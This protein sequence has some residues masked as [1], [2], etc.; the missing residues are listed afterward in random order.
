MAT[1]EQMIG[2]NV[3]H[4]LRFEILPSHDQDGNP[5][6]GG[7][8]IFKAT[9]ETVEFVQSLVNEGKRLVLESEGHIRFESDLDDEPPHLPK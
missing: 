6:F 5:I 7:P 9:A 8:Q 3:L 1:Q 4:E 2:N